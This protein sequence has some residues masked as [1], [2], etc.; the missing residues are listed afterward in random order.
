MVDQWSAATITPE[1]KSLVHDL[2]QASREE[3][4]VVFVI[5]SALQCRRRTLLQS[6]ELRSGHRTRL[7]QHNSHQPLSLTANFYHIRLIVIKFN[8]SKN[9]PS[10]NDSFIHSSFILKLIL[11][12]STAT[13]H[14]CSCLL[15]HWLYSKYHRSLFFTFCKQHPFHELSPKTSQVRDSSKKLTTSLSPLLVALSFVN[16]LQSSYYKSFSLP[17]LS[18]D[19]VTNRANNF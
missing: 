10:L 2:H 3:L 16:V 4:R 14:I 15:T 1:W 6:S 17:C 13:R 12:I 7:R 9:D 19:F 18:A 5:F 8:K 11:T